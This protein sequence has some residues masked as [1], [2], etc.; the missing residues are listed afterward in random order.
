MRVFR[1]SAD[2]LPVFTFTLYFCAVLYFYA[3]VESLPWMLGWTVVSVLPNGWVS[4]FNHH[5][6]H[7]ATFRS[8]FLNRALELMYALQTGVTGH[9]WVLHH[10]LGHHLNYLDQTKD[11]SR[12]RDDE[13]KPMGM[14]RYTWVTAVSAYPRAWEVGRRHPAHRRTFAWMAVLTVVVLA[15]LI[16]YRPLQG[17]FV[18]ALPMVIC[19]VATVWATHGHH[20]GNDTSSHFVASNNSLNRLYNFCTGNLGYH[21]AHHY[22]PGLHWS[23]LPEL[24]AEI[25]HEIPASCYVGPGLFY[26]GFGLFPDQ[27]PTY[28]RAASSLAEL[29]AP[30]LDGAETAEATELHEALR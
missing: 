13:G 25:A 9:A 22:R 10:S 29:R 21:T 8:P 5:H 28:T 30:A 16:A 4:A 18:F 26:D 6:Q 1:H 24:H 3:H 7:V 20:T 23:K 15:G 27:I 17:I 2:R 11:E 14:L 19:M 12:W